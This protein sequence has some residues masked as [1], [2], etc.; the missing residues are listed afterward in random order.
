MMIDLAATEQGRGLAEE[1][2]AWRKPENSGRRSV[3]FGMT[4]GTALNNHTSL[5][6][7]DQHRR[8]ERRTIAR[9]LSL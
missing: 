1:R 5:R 9:I 8:A 3:G 4:D 2:S 6:L 7:S